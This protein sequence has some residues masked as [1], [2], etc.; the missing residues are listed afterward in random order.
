MD[1]APLLQWLGLPPGSWP[2]EDRTLLGLPPAPAVVSAAEAEQQALARMETLRPHQLRHP[3]LVTEGM[4]RLAQALIAVMAAA[5]VPEA[6]FPPPR[7]RRSARPKSKPRIEPLPEPLPPPTPGGYDFSPVSPPAS[8]P[9]PPPAALPPPPPVILDAEVIATRPDGR[10]APTRRPP[11]PA[12]VRKAV[13]P[14]P[15]VTVPEPPE[16]TNYFPAKRRQGYR[17]LVFLRRLRACW[18]LLKRTVGDANEPLTSAEAVYELLHGSRQLATLRRREEFERVIRGDAEA[19]A[20]VTVQPAVLTVLRELVPSQRWGLAVAWDA[21]RLA[22]EK[23]EKWLRERMRESKPARRTQPS[24][25]GLGGLL[26][27]NPE[28]VLLLLTGLAL[29]IGIAR[30]VGRNSS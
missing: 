17:E 25:G 5:P 1:T 4:N 10:S 24:S 28:W 23:R 16:G 3:E 9:T 12:P 20:S 2:P 19:V 29:A 26:R 15:P 22:I 7:P 8:A 18:A 21:G 11:E 30:A 27:D 14:L 13:L 6:V